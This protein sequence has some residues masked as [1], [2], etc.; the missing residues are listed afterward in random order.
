MSPRRESTTVLVTGATGLMG[1]TLL[2]LLATQ[3][4]FHI[5]AL[6]RATSTTDHLHDLAPLIEWREGDLLDVYSLEEA[7]TNVA[8]VFHCAGLTHSTGA[9]AQ[10]IYQTN[11]EGTANVVNAA[12]YSGVRRI[13]HVS[14]VAALNRHSSQPIDETADWES[15]P[16]NSSYAES[17][18]LAEMELWRGMAEGLEAIAVLP[19]YLL[20]PGF[21]DR[22]P[23][24]LFP[25]IY[26]GLP[27]YPQ[28]SA[29]F[30]DVRDVAHFM[31]QAASSA[32][33]G[34][35]YILN[36]VNLSWQALLQAIASALQ[37]PSPRYALPLWAHPLVSGVSWLRSRLG[38]KN[39]ILTRKRM[40]QLARCYHYDA[41]KSLQL[42]PNLYR[43]WQQTVAELAAAFL[44]YLR[45]KP[46]N[47]G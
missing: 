34:Q 20:G 39:H 22:G 45:D 2:R 27:F 17:K 44:Q 46:H 5:R 6:R 12:L 30:V 31:V 25:M 41:R 26:R 10:Q 9:S 36:A 43:P 24:Q 21:W 11:V 16:H 37:V 29:G 19:T 18:H 13:V 40:H 32:P 38:K 4:H 42:A 33:S 8:I 35:R 1:S 23:A 7:M 15:H 28:G 14:S 47:A 3:S